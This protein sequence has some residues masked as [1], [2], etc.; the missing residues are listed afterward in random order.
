MNFYFYFFL[1]QNYKTFIN[2]ETKFFSLEN[3]NHS[4]IT[5]TMM[6]IFIVWIVL[7]KVDKFF[8]SPLFS[9]LNP[10]K[11]IQKHFGELKLDTENININYTHKHT[12]KHATK[13]SFCSKKKFNLNLNF[14]F[15]KNQRYQK[16]CFFF[17]SVCSNH[18]TSEIINHNHKYWTIW[19]MFESLREICWY[20]HHQQDL[21]IRYINAKKKTFER[22]SSL[23]HHIDRCFILSFLFHQQM[24]ILILF[25][26]FWVDNNHIF[27]QTT[28]EKSFDI[29]II[30]S[31]SNK[32]IQNDFCS[33]GDNNDDD[34]MKTK[35]FANNNFHL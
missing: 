21:M 4:I 7:V 23:S 12:E 27:F 18:Q 28:T 3:F 10:K 14:F 13:Q 25:N 17:V 1:S 33:Q 26:T 20:H 19:K 34:D 31:T 6:I 15:F 24:K 5:H 11:T 22:W 32:Q 35:N 16:S 30:I 9:H 29:I 2:F 8:H